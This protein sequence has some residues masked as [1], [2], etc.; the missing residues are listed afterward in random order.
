MLEHALIALALH[1]GRG[2]MLRVHLH[3]C[4]P[5]SSHLARDFRHGKK[6]A[7]PDPEKKFY[8][9]AVIKV[10]PDEA[11]ATAKVE[12][13]AKDQPHIWLIPD[14]ATPR[15]NL[16]FDQQSRLWKWLTS[17]AGLFSGTH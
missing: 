6:K 1:C 17:T 10:A 15:Q 4:V 5:K 16:T 13:L 9:T 8:V 3:K 12:E 14:T 11:P 2:E 7:A